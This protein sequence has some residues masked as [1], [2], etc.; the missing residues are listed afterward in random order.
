MNLEQY[1][2]ISG[3]PGIYKMVNN[4]NTGLILEDLESGRKR[5]YSAM[6]HQFTPLGTISIYT[7]MDSE[8]LDKVFQNMLDQFEDNPPP[9]PKGK[10][11][12]VLEYF[13]DVLPQYDK[14]KVSIGD[15]RKIIKWFNFLHDRGLL[16]EDE[17]E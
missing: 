12:I 6:R 13:E 14:D 9:P 4:K 1:I 16:T 17:E 3:K 8:P 2:S 10:A 7:M 15:I 5:F 11:E